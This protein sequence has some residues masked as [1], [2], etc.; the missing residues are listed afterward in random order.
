MRF[1]LVDDDG[2][3]RSVMRHIIEGE[4][5]GSVIG[6]AETGC[7]VTSNVLQF[8][9]I[10]I[11]IMDLLMPER[12]GIETIKSWNR[13]FKGK[14]IML[15]QVETKELIGDAYAEGVDYYVTKPINKKELV[16]VINKVI[17]SIQLEKTVNDIRCSLN[18]LL[19]SNGK[20]TADGTAVAQAS[21]KIVE[22]A[23]FLL[24]ELGI[25]GENGSKDLLEMVQY[26]YEHEINDG[27]DLHF[28]SLKELFEKLS[29][30]RLG[31]AASPLE[32]NRETKASEQRVRRAIYQSIT[33]WANI[34][35]SASTNAKFENYATK[36]FDFSTIRCKMTELSNE[37]EVSPKQV[38]IHTKKFIQVL[39]FEAKKLSSSR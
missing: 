16:A 39:Y 10:D 22:S 20:N 19:T 29:F 34:G 13:E 7:K 26:L 18:S 17:Q 27:F 24:S 30:M 12:D 32:L 28:P 2:A 38:K 4:K 5:L 37:Q 15:S 36:F 9:D 21:V 14:V 25:I 23:E 3:I 1:F 31:E 33:H 8:N 6:E 11:V 35:L